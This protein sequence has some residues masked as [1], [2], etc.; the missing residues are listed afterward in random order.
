M[1]TRRRPPLTFFLGGGGRAYEARDSFF[2]QLHGPWSVLGPRVRPNWFRFGRCKEFLYQCHC[3]V[4]YW[5]KAVA[6]HGGYGFPHIPIPDVGDCRIC[7]FGWVIEFDGARLS[8]QFLLFR[9]VS[10]FLFGGPPFQA[11]RPFPAAPGIFLE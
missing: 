1:S 9:L 8:S 5:D 10:C 6:C 4:V 2:L 7:H 11:C 3:I